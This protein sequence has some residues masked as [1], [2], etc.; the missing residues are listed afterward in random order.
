LPTTTESGDNHNTSSSGYF[1]LKT[2]YWLK[3]VV[4]MAAVAAYMML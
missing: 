1:D 3:K 4:L 2:S